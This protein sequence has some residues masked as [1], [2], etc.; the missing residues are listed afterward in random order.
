MKIWNNLILRK[1]MEFIDKRLGLVL[2]FPS[3]SFYNSL[4]SF[5]LGFHSPNQAET[6]LNSLERAAAAIGLH[7]KL[8]LK[9][10]LVSYPARAKELVKIIEVPVV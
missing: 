7:V 1:I 5:K 2:S 10:D 6:L 4:K 3:S 8:R 9:T